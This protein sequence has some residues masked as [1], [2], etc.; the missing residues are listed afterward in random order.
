LKETE[1]ANQVKSAPEGGSNPGTSPLVWGLRVAGLVVFALLQAA[2]RRRRTVP[3]QRD[4]VST[5]APPAPIAS[6]VCETVRQ[7]PMPAKAA[8]KAPTL[9]GFID[10]N[11]KLISVLGVFTAICLFVGKLPIQW[12]AYMLSF[13]FMVLT[14]ILWLELWSKFPSG[15]GDWKITT[16]ENILMIAVFTLLTYVL[17]DF[18]RLWK[19]SY[20]MLLI[21]A[22]I[23]GG[24]SSVMKRFDLFN[25]LFR[26]RP[27]ERRWLRYLLGVA[28]L[29]VVGIAS[30][31]LANW[32]APALNHVLDAMYK[33]LSEQP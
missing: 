5:G 6:T 3:K 8:K 16:F 27:G 31:M 30:I 23:L 1:M 2:M 26:C 10:E 14:V 4:D 11:Q 18:R 19:S 15:S 17:V 12:F 24:F 22:I 33:S 7:E 25:R 20:L 9:S 28:V 32:I 13:M 21:F 29:S